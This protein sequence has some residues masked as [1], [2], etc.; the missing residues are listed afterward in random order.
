MWPAYVINLAVNKRR[1]D[2]SARQ[3]DAQRIAWRRIDAVDGRALQPDEIARVYD[4]EVNR[5]RARNPLTSPEIGCY[6]SHIAAWRAIA[7]G[8]ARGGFVFEDD[9]RAGPALRETLGR[10][11]ADDQR[12]RWDIVKLFSLKPEPR[13]INPTPLGAHHRV[14]IAY[15]VPACTIA[16]GITRDA[17]ARLAASAAPFF[18]AVDEDQKFFWERGLNVALVTPPPVTDAGQDAVAGTIGEVRRKAAR[19]DRRPVLSR[20][21]TNFTYQADYL[22]RLHL[23]RLRGIGR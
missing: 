18:R 13:L 10:L 8:D 12:A 19:Q 16:Y 5:K 4:A 14:G 15:R 6:L 1:M 3:L 9:F 20:A 7:A 17:A 22:A 23:N 2:E 21:L 11:S